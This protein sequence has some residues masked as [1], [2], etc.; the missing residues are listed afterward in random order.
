MKRLAH[1]APLL[2]WAFR[3]WA[4]FGSEPAEDGWVAAAT[5]EACE[6]GRLT[7][8]E[9]AQRY[10]TSIDLGECRWITPEDLQRLKPEDKRHR[11]PSAH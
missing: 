2:I 11:Y 1:G 9:A 8:A 6:A 4:Q 7:Y 3:V 5:L 10:Q